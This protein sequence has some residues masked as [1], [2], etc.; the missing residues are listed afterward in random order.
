M[1]EPTPNRQKADF[2]V[3]HYDNEAVSGKHQYVRRGTLTTQPEGNQEVR[4]SMGTH[5]CQQHRQ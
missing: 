2:S 1:I 4:T 5:C 3:S